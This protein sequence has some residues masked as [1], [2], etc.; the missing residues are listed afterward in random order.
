MTTDAHHP[1][2]INSL[3]KATPKLRR[4]LA[5]RPQSFGGEACYVV[6]DPVSSRFFRIGVDEYAFISLLD[7]AMTVG[8]A[9]GATVKA[10]PDCGFTPPDALAIC[11]W[12]VRNGLAHDGSEDIG[13]APSRG[14]SVR[15]SQRRGARLTALSVQIPLF[16]PDRLFTGLRFWL[17]WCFS[18]P[19]VLA[20]LLVLG[21]AVCDLIV[22]ADRVAGSSST[23]LAPHNWIWLGAAW[24]ALKVIHECGHGIACKRLGGEVREA[25]VV[26]VLFAPL[27]YVDVTSS[28]RLRSK[29]ARIQVAAAGMYVELFVAAVAMLLWS[30]TA[31]GVLNQFCFNVM[32]TASVMTVLFNANPLMRFDGYYMLSD[33]LELPNLYALGQRYVSC[34]TRRHLFGMRSAGPDLHGLRSMLVR[35]YGFASLFWRNCVFVGLV[36]TAATLLQGAGI[37]LSVVAVSFWIVVMGR[38]ALR[39]AGQSTEGGRPNWSRFALVGGG[40]AVAAAVLLAFVPWP[41]SVAAPAI[42]RYAPMTAVRCDS[43]AFVREIRVRSGQHVQAGQVV[44]VLASDELQHELAQLELAIRRSQIAQRVHRKKAEM[45]KA[46]AESEQLRTLEKRWKEKQE[47]VSRLIVRAPCAG[48]VIGR[49]LDALQGTYLTKGSEILSIGEETAKEVRLSIAQHDVHA[50]RARHGCVLRAYFPDGLVVEA[51][52]SKIE[53]RGSVVPIERSLCVPAGGDLPVRKVDQDSSATGADYQLLS[54]RFTGIMPL[55]AAHSRLVPAG[56]RAHVALRPRES[57]GQHLW[58]LLTDWV[59]RRLGR[60]TR[61]ATA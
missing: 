14:G 56:R 2:L 39:F 60:K 21:C 5:F 34:F 16:R 11:Q 30:R 1:P 50:F 18:F 25:G 51:A 44:A 19:A 22:H 33:F 9:L 55:D 46:Q 26:F 41:G 61:V 42:V 8:E 49:N 10:R 4:E 13:S 59:D 45:A 23:I 48:N 29:W 37:V 36:L 20:W 15:P 43:D 12:V 47:E 58:Q 38:R 24:I 3:D 17:G 27:A 40:G 54:P 32:M 52:L 31:P 57:V 7:G 53:P 35:F 28:W 6:E